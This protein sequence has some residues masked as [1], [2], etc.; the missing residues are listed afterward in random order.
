MSDVPVIN[1][2][3]D[4]SYGTAADEGDARSPLPHPTASF[5]VI[6][7]RA[8]TII[9]YM[10]STWF[11]S[12]F[13]LVFVTC[14]LLCAADFWTVKNVSG[15]LL[16]GLRWW[17]EVDEKGENQWF[18]ECAEDTSGVDDRERR[19]FWGG[20]YITPIIWV[21]LS[22][23]CVLQFSF[24]WLMVCIMAL[25]MT[26]T[27]LVGYHRCQKDANKKLKTAAQNF[28]FDQAAAFMRSS[29]NAT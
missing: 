9:W 17:S 10:F 20:L 24:K 21:L 8:T 18:F 22:V 28:V 29:N 12:N 25:I 14:V 2:E 15:R 13:V 5:F 11:T 27:N 1:N 23:G 16:V 19:L 3:G 26:S 4:G 6:F 7:F